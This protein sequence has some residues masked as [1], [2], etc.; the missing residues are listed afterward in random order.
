M[1]VVGVDMAANVGDVSVGGTM[2]NVGDVVML[3]AEVGVAELTLVVLLVVVVAVFIT[4]MEG[5]LREG[6]DG[7]S[8]AGGGA[9]K[10]DFLLS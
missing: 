3:V 1:V 4:G 5:T 6:S 2:A 9:K 7:T 8:S 10:T